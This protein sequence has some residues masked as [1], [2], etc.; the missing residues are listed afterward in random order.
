MNLKGGADISFPKDLVKLVK[1]EGLDD[2]VIFTGSVER[3][4]IPR[5]IAESLVGVAPLKNLQ[6]L[7]YT[8]STKVY[9]YMSCGIPFIAAEKG[10]I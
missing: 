2:V 1:K 8:I 5:L 6:C 3:E 7:D 4:K 9:E 10:E